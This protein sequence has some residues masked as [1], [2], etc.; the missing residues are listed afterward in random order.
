M[1]SYVPWSKRFRRSDVPTCIDLFGGAG[2]LSLGF[3]Q[4]GGIPVAAVDNHPDSTVT[5]RKMFPMATDV[6]CGDIEAW[7][8]QRNHVG[9]VDVLIGG[10]PC[11]GFSL[12]RGLRFVDDP[13]N[14]LYKHYVRLVDFFDPEWV[15][16]ENVPGITNIGDGVIL[17][18]IYEDF[19]RLGYELSHRVINMA[20]Y[21]VPQ[22]RTRAIFVGNRIAKTFTWPAPTHTPAARTDNTLFGEVNPYVPVRS[23]LEDLPWPMA[24]FFSHRANSQMRGPRNR[25]MLS[26]PAFT[27]RVRGDEFG[28]CEVPA[29]GPFVPGPL[30]EVE[31]SYGP[32]SHPYQ[33]IMRERPPRW[34]AAS[35]ARTEHPRRKDKVPPLKGTRRLAMREQARLQSFPDW[36]EFA[37]KP[38]SQSRQIGNAVPPLFAQQ[39]FRQIFDASNFHTKSLDENLANPPQ[40]VGE[41]HT[42]ARKSDSC[43]GQSHR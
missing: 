3:A 30:P 14:Q 15:V 35:R 24:N 11:G 9:K 13:R 38:Y 21:G 2:G 31:M 29:T 40:I 36:F 5:Y 22:T 4:A 12:A 7:H 6:H 25:S 18:Q 33:A 20:Q 26:D 41:R 27:L 1:S 23:A 34:I 32:T 10:P 39:L 42:V 37:G 43:V 19:G 17:R 8:P 28:L 16:I